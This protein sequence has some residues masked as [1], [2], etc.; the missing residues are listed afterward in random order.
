V[1]IT[2]PY[3]D[4]RRTIE[5]FED[6]RFWA[7][8]MRIKHLGTLERQVALGFTLFFVITIA[9]SAFVYLNRT[10]IR[11]ESRNDQEAGF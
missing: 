10:P 3:G 7:T 9:V 2:L 11:V 5:D 8:D 1:K 4:N 6:L